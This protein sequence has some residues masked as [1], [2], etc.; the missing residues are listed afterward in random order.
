LGW[1][2]YK[3]RGHANY[4]LNPGG[5]R[6]AGSYRTG[7]NAQELIDKPRVSARMNY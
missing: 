3:I 7:G 4:E 2:D 6:P 5:N 1:A